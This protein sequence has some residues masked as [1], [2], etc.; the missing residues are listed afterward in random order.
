MGTQ[1]WYIE[2]VAEYTGLARSSVQS[3]NGRS[4]M[5]RKKAAETGDQKHIKRGDMPPPDGREGRWPYSPWW[6]QDTI[7][8]WWANRPGAYNQ[9]WIEQNRDKIGK[10]KQDR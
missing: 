8:N 10:R 2:D 7:K 4:Q 1:V 5:H 6:H 3:M 9:A